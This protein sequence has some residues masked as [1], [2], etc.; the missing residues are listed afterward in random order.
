MPRN[1][2]TMGRGCSTSLV[3]I[4]C[5]RLQ[6]LLHPR[7]ASHEPGQLHFRLI[8]LRFVCN[9]VRRVKLPAELLTLSYRAAR[10][11]SINSSAI[12]SSIGPQF[13]DYIKRGQSLP[14]GYFF[15]GFFLCNAPRGLTDAIS[16]YTEWLMSIRS[17]WFQRIS[18]QRKTQWENNSVELRDS[19]KVKSHR[20][21]S[22]NG[23]LFI[24]VALKIYR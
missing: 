20:D 21:Y 18:R 13:V 3:C 12:R 5:K 10:G 1:D 23:N 11:L 4:V 14:L 7:V 15:F 16:L 19:R 8:G 2:Y 6:L 24:Y 17:I 22:T 9:Y